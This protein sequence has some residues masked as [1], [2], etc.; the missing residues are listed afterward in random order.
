MFEG[1]IGDIIKGVTAIFFGVILTAVSLIAVKRKVSFEEKY[2][3]IF[4]IGLLSI[5]IGL[6]FCLRGIL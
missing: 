4:W 6:W 1:V 5:T 3:V 2:H